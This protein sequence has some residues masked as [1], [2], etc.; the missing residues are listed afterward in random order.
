MVV[1]S[2]FFRFKQTELRANAFVDKEDM[3]TISLNFGFNFINI[4]FFFI[5]S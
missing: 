3:L 5:I 2:L 4:F 1:T